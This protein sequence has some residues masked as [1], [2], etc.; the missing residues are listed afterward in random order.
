MQ[1]RTWYWIIGA[2]VVILILY[3]VFG[4]SGT[5]TAEEPTAPATTETA[6]AAPAETAPAPAN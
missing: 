5:E 4:S 6:P 2:I 1:R 3:F